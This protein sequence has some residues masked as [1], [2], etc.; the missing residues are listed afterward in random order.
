[1]RFQA[2]HENIRRDLEENVWYKKDGKSNV[3][4]VAF[5]MQILRKVQGESIRYIDAKSI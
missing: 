2:S 4:L 3:F 1:M 5:E